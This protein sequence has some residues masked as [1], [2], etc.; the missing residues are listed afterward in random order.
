MPKCQNAW[1]ECQFG[2]QGLLQDLS[3]K[4]KPSNFV[5][6][7]PK[8]PLQHVMLLRTCMRRVGLVSRM[9]QGAGNPKATLALK[10][11]QSL[12]SLPE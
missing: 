11:S 4:V 1:C 9:Y 3:V 8:A 6:D 7:A 10:I 5:V 2:T 12:G